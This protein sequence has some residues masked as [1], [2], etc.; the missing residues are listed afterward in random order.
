MAFV[1]EVF[2]DVP[3]FVVGEDVF[4]LVGELP[5]DIGRLVAVRVV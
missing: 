5:V 2:V 4:R 3:A 1:L